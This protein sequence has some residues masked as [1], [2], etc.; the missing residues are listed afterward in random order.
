MDLTL[1]AQAILSGK[2]MKRLN[3]AAH[4]A[5]IHDIRTSA[6]AAWST[7]MR[8]LLRA[9]SWRAVRFS[10]VRSFSWERKSLV[11]LAVGHFLKTS[12]E[13]SEVK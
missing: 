8:R 10:S 13:L 2:L 6:S 9:F 1:V 11:S 4:T 3:G 12:V 7:N 5:C